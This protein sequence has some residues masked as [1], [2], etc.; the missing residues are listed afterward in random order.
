MSTCCAGPKLPT[1]TATKASKAASP[2]QLSPAR[3]I[4]VITK[5]SVKAGD[6]TCKRNISVLKSWKAALTAVAL[7]RQENVAVCV[8]GEA[9]QPAQQ[10]LARVGRSARVA[11]D[12]GFVFSVFLFSVFL[13][14]GV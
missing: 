11:W 12:C 4:Y 1:A 10:K 3:K 9:L 7:A 5:Q 13:P 6:L 14:G 8:L 2:P